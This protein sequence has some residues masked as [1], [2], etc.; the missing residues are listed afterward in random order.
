MDIIWHKKR[1][2]GSTV[3]RS[4]AYTV[5]FGMEDW[6]LDGNY[7]EVVRIPTV[8]AKRKRNRLKSLVD[9]SNRFYE[10]SS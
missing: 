8:H 5:L 10:G 9:K 7:A 3:G 4:M 1:P 6:V 2:Y